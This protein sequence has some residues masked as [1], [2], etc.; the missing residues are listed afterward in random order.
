MGKTPK[1]PVL[2][3]YH[4]Q[5]GVAYPAT[6]REDKAYM[7]GEKIAQFTNHGIFTIKGLKLSKRGKIKCL[8]YLDGKSETAHLKVDKKISGKEKVNS[9]LQTIPDTQET[10]FEP[11]TDL[12]RK[13]V[14][15]REIAKQLGKF[16]AM[17]TW[18]FIVIIALLGV[19]IA[20]RFI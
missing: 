13:T 16:K 12:D 20:L 9:T 11:L 3:F 1:I 5:D 8:L 4:N 6:I 2:H 18:Q 10:I 14:V 19:S 17:E 15:K 7:R